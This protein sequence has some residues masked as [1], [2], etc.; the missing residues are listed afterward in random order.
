MVCGGQCLQFLYKCGLPFTLGLGMTK[1]GPNLLKTKP[2]K[3]IISSERAY[4]CPNEF[5]SNLLAPGRCE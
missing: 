1:R 3:N 5:T 2:P 4:T